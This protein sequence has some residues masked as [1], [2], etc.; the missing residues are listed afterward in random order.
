M[1]KSLAG[2]FVALLVVAPA[3]AQVATVQVQ[4]LGQG[5]TADTKLTLSAGIFGN[6][7][8]W[9][10]PRILSKQTV[11]L[12]AASLLQPEVCAE[13]PGYQN[14]SIT[15]MQLVLKS[16][17]DASTFHTEAETVTPKNP[18]SIKVA[19]KERLWVVYAAPAN[20]PAT[21]RF[22]RTR[23]AAIQTCYT[24]TTTGA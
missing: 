17:V 18:L 2:Y 20:Q 15:V 4:S 13:F 7:S 8:N 19:A 3:S 6:T 24:S 21:L 12:P 1:M 23:P 14:A 5:L 22:Y 9:K 16:T 10:M 11:N